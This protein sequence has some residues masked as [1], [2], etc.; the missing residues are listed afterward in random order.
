WTHLPI[1]CVSCSSP[2]GRNLYSSL[3]SRCELS[4]DRGYKLLGRPSVQCM[5]SR[6]W[7]GTAYCRR[8]RCHVLPLISHGT[9]HCPDGTVV[10]SRCEYMCDPGHQIEGDR[11]RICQDG[12]SWSGSEPTCADLEPPKIKCPASKVKVA[13]P[14]KLTAKVSWDRPQVSDSAGKSLDLMR[15]GPESGSV[16]T[17]G[18]HII[19]YRVYDQAK[20]RAA[21]K[22]SVHI[23]VKRCPALKPPIH[24]YLTCSSSK[25]NYGAVCES[26]CESG[27]ERQGPAT[28][29]CQFNR[30]WSD[31]PALCTSMQIKTDVRTAAA[32]L[33]QFYEK[34]RLL[35]VSTPD[36]GNEY[37]K[38][39]NIML[40][41]ADCGLDLRHVTVIELLGVQPKE[42][43]RIKGRHLDTQVVEDL[44]QSLR[45]ST[46]YFTMV[47][48]DEYGMDR[49]RFVNPASS[50][51]L[52]AHIEDFLLDEDERERLEANREFCD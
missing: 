51:E 16:F 37:Y 9:Y 1:Q 7:S 24:G 44:R 47:L 19:R 15:V 39:Q 36:L 42:V 43:G 23:E 49:E 32:L 48:L 8:V 10:D 25:N 6:R 22:F 38:L 13:E 20:N 17:E 4:C 45:I 35:V 11:L 18:I 21:C 3:G 52:F 30:S 41:K 26:H 12:G 31:E 28:R 29:V 50:E 2:Y 34:R 5:A 33:D 14:D 27:Y 46:S 40:Q